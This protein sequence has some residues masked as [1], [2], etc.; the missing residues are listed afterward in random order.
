MLS[1]GRWM[2]EQNLCVSLRSPSTSLDRRSSVTVILAITSEVQVLHVF[3][4]K[5]AHW[6][7]ESLSIFVKAHECPENMHRI[8][9]R[10]SGW[11]ESRKVHDRVLEVKTA[12]R[13]EPAIT[14]W[15]TTSRSYPEKIVRRSLKEE[16]TGM[17][18][19]DWC[20]NEEDE[21]TIPRV[22]VFH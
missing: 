14:L 20:Q 1:R 9:V 7:A 19:F 2:D 16:F 12:E 4:D 21:R 13:I 18:G 22:F 17:K 15:A 5:K 6:R 3:I 11:N 8:I 10:I